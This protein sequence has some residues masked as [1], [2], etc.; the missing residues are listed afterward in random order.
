MVDAQSRCAD[1]WDERHGMQPM[2]LHNLVDGGPV[3]ASRRRPRE[4]VGRTIEPRLG[5]A[6][7]E[8]GEIRHVVADHTMA[9]R[10]RGRNPLAAA[11]RTNAR[12][13]VHAP[14]A[15]TPLRSGADSGEAGAHQHALRAVRSST[16]DQPELLPRRLSAT[17]GRPNRSPRLPGADTD[18]C[19]RAGLDGEEIARLRA[20]GAIGSL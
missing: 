19:S 16:R 2:P 4:G 9:P 14:R 18:A 13:M 10:G 7:R 6:D 3:Y 20:A 12:T 11:F 8:V 5:A 17:P 1:I 15:R